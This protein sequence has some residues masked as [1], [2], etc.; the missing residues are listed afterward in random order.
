MECSPGQSGMILCQR[1]STCRI[2]ILPFFIISQIKSLVFEDSNYPYTNRGEVSTIARCPDQKSVCVGYTTG[3]VRVFNYITGAIVTTYRGHRSAVNAIAL[4]TSANSSGSLLATGG[5][6]CDIVVW[7]QVASLGLVRFREHKDAVTALS[8][9][10]VDDRKFLVS[11]SKDTLLKVWDVDNKYCLQTIV[12][13]RTEIWSLLVLHPTEAE[14]LRILTG[15]A[16]EQVRAYALT[17]SV[18]TSEMLA[19]LEG[20]VE[21]NVLTYVGS[22]KRTN[23]GGNID[24]C[25]GLTADSVRGLVA[26]QSSGK[27]VDI[28]R[29]RPREEA[30]KKTKKRLKRIEEKKSQG[31]VAAVRDADGILLD[32]EAGIVEHDTPIL[33]EWNILDEI[34]LI[35]TLRSAVRVK[36][37]EFT[38]VPSSSSSLINAASTSED[39]TALVAL[40]NNSLE[41]Y[42]VPLVH[43]T[44]GLTKHSVVDFAGHRSDVRG[45]ALTHDGITLATCS[46]ESIKVIVFICFVLFS[47]AFYNLPFV[48]LAVLELEESRVY[49]ILSCQWVLSFDRFC[50]WRT[51]HSCWF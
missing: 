7:D 30:K 36:S 33:T 27:L 46:S 28:Y 12:G 32:E 29:L 16:D 21:E 9:V 47:G 31:K 39:A 40:A 5:A 44:D 51:L 38:P 41:S 10:N 43:T 45:L 23:H 34:E 6:D 3:E 11:V 22:L 4:D 50:S 26:A 1:L 42:K 13:H 2:M 15:S 24:R 37:F 25:A 35:H 20:A 8:F 49:W 17:Q 14:Y 19:T 18:L 48:I